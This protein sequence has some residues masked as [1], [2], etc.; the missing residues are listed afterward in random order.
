MSRTAIIAWIMGIVGLLGTLGVDLPADTIETL[1]NSVSDD[2]LELYM[3]ISG[4]VMMW[5]RKITDSPVA[6]GISGWLGLKG[7]GD[8]S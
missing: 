8:G 4:A 5:L 3:I 1:L 7:T 2:A 6:K